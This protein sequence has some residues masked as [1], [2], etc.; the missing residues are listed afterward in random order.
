MINMLTSLSTKNIML[1]KDIQKAGLDAKEAKVYLAAL[2]L[3]ETNIGRLAKKSGVK[4]TTVYLAIDSLKQKGLMSEL[5]K[6]N[7]TFFYA[8]SPKKLSDNINENKIAID[9]LMPELLSLAN[10]ID[11]KPKIRFFEGMEGIKEVYKDTLGTPDQEIVTWF[12]DDFFD[13]DKDFF[14]NYYIPT[15]IKKKIWV[16]AILPDTEKMHHVVRFDEKQLRRSKLIPKD[17]YKINIEFSVYG[18]NK[19]ALISYKDDLALIIESQRIH[20]SIKSM[21][22]IM[23]SVLP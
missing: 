22:E 12:S 4:R 14:D 2:E 7:K 6:R 23:W 17:K 19:V 3:G 18:K 13:F 20:D 5:K 8:E 1:S 10:L 21:F 9:G 15:R 16:R 11:K